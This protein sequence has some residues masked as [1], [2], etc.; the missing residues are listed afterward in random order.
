M[1]KTDK[2]LW[3]ATYFAWK[4]KPEIERGGGNSFYQ[5]Q[6]SRGRRV[7]LR[8]ELGW[9]RIALLISFIVG[10]ERK[11]FSPIPCVLGR[12]QWNASS[13]FCF[14]L[15]FSTNFEPFFR[16]TTFDAF[17]AIF[18]FRANSSSLISFL[19]ES[20]FCGNLLSVCARAI[21]Y[22]RQCCGGRRREIC[23]GEWRRPWGTLRLIVL[24]AVFQEI[25]VR[26]L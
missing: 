5:G 8:C 24:V 13:R 20:S 3:Y 19:W 9:W 10:A 4:K 26:K 22:S 1:H 12:S 11:T 17:E 18:L 15:F 14:Y 23:G 21:L 25:N 16:F 6:I 2:Y 7:E